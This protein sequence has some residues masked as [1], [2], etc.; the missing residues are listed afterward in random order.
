MIAA[1]A[2]LAGCGQQ[3]Y[4]TQDFQATAVAGQ[5][6]VTKPK[7]DIIVF[8]DNSDSY[9]FGPISTLKPQ[10]VNL[11][12]SLNNKW[13]IHFTVLPLLTVKS[14]TQKFVVATNCNEIVVGPNVGG[15]NA[16]FSPAQSAQFNNNA[17]DLGWINSVNSAAGSNDKGFQTIYSSLMQSSINTSQFRRP[18]AALAV[19]VLSNGEDT[20]G[21]GYT[22][23]SDKYEYLDYDHPDS[24]S[25]FISY[26][27]SFASYFTGSASI[28]R[29]F[30][31]VSQHGG[32]CLGHGSFEGRRYRE[33]SEALGS[34]SYD[35]C[36]GGIGVSLSSMSAQLQTVIEAF[37]FNYVVL[38]DKPVVSSIVIK[39]N[40]EVVPQSNVNGWS[41]VGYQNNQPT[42]YS[43]VS[44][45]NRTGY[46]IQM[47]GTAEY[48]GSDVITISYQKE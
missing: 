26:K 43:P 1:L 4:Q 37:I 35:L 11:L 40:G 10:M 29:F 27:N 31:V 30:S 20:S 38:K 32:T 13:D 28:S 17:G 8:Q 41:Y 47:N 39:K 24:I 12:N 19:L 22:L 3:K 42:S 33:M 5:Y 16:C 36:N 34:I 15:V 6:S 46:F 18:D 14:L 44:G 7:I 9:M 23:R 21:V 48:K 2:V 45:N 25:S